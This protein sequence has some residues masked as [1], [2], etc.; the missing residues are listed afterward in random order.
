MSASIELGVWFLYCLLV[1]GTPVTIHSTSIL[2]RCLISRIQQRK[3][4]KKESHTQAQTHRHAVQYHAPAN[5]IQKKRTRHGK[6]KT[7][8]SD[9]M[10]ADIRVTRKCNV[11]I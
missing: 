8:T 7:E 11:W 3:E 9:K 6:H 2:N 10:M 1:P 5:R 4:R